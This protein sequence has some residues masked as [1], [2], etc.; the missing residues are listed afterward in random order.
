MLL[1]LP[2]LVAVVLAAALLARR[3]L[4]PAPP[5]APALVAYTPP[6][7]VVAGGIALGAQLYGAL[8]GG[9]FDTLDAESFEFLVGALGAGLFQSGTLVALGVLIALLGR[10]GA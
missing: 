1:A 4:L 5:D 2:V 3:T 8:S 7:L 9:A 6:A 10:R